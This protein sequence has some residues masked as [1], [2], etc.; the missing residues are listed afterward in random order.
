MNKVY[1]ARL[2]T[3]GTVTVSVVGKKFANDS[4]GVPSN[5]KG[6]LKLA[7]AKGIGALAVQYLQTKKIVPDDPLNCTS[8]QLEQ[9]KAFQSQSR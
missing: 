5:P 8:T 1:D 6:I 2:I 4:L 7:V 3:F 9:A